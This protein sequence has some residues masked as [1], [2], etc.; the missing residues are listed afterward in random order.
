MR[1]GPLWWCLVLSL[2]AGCKS[3]Y[4]PLNPAPGLPP[5]V[6]LD[7]K[8]PVDRL[9]TESVRA[10]RAVQ[11]PG[12]PETRDEAAFTTE[13]RFTPSD[14]G[15]RVTQAVRTP[16]QVHAGQDVPS[17]AG[18]VLERFTLRMQ[19]AA[20][21]TFVKLVGAEAAEE[22][23]RQVAPSGP[24]VAEVARFFTPEALEIRTRR[25]WEAKYSG[26]LQRNLVEGQRTWAVDF[27]SVDGVERAYL[28]ERTVDGTRPTMFGDA[29]A[30]SLTC[31]D[32]LPTK[33]PAEMRAAWSEAGS[34]ELF[35]GVT[36]EGEQV[37]ARGRFV[38]VRRLL[39]VKAVGEG[40]TVTLTTESQAETLQEEGP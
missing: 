32:A 10:T 19:L 7:F 14:G 1:P 31:L 24:G 23:L 33:A 36:C 26:L 15:W 13:T 39:K 30:L 18:A 29:V 22:A 16:R 5:P 40:G 11:R 25:E 37:I 9:L 2:A 34:P 8:P 17:L 35:K 38:P 6:R 12:Q 28:L 3:R 4:P 27:V 21:G 20:D